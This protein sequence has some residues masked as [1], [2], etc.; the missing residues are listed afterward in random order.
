M[1][2][3]YIITI[4]TN[5]LD[6]A[7]HRSYTTGLQWRVE[8]NGSYIHEKMLISFDHHISEQVS[9][10]CVHMLAC[11]S[12]CVLNAVTGCLFLLPP[13][14]KVYMEKARNAPVKFRL[15]T[16]LLLCDH[17][18]YSGLFYSGALWHPVTTYVISLD[19]SCLLTE[20]RWQAMCCH[21]KLFLHL[22]IHNVTYC[23]IC[24]DDHP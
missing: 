9:S 2:S 3:V 21:F 22:Y 13:G 4:T 5:Y 12:V 20:L 14:S 6:T 7:C 15:T 8:W 24:T 10:L 19:C 11:V 17:L 18:Q 16:L 23:M 1:Y